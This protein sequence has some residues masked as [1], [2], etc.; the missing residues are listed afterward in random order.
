[1]AEQKLTLVLDETEVDGLDRI[2]RQEL[3]PI[4][5]QARFMLRSE[6]ARRGLLP[7]PE[8]PQEASASR[9]A[10]PA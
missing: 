9:P 7:S 8:L 10:V 2:A 3:R 6:L 5:D 1:M 4:K